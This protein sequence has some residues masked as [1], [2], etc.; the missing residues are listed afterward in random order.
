MNIDD[1]HRCIYK[2]IYKHTHVYM[3]DMISSLIYG[4]GCDLSWRM[5]HV[6]LRRM[7]ILFS[8]G[9]LNKY[10]LSPFGL[11]CYL[12]PMLPY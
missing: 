12:K 9:M 5:T 2:C 1:I 3:L 6:C 8:D 4:S 11:M 10:Q 7:C